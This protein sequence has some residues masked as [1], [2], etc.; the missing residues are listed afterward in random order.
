[1]VVYFNLELL[2]VTDPHSVNHCL[3]LDKADYGPHPE[4]KHIYR[5]NQVFYLHL[6]AKIANP[7]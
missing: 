3:K 5:Q 2:R 7:A 6:C 4:P 1:M